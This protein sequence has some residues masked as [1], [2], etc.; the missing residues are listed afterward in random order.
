MREYIDVHCHLDGDEYDELGGLDYLVENALSRNVKYLV[1][2]GT[3]VETSYKAK[4]IAEKYENVYFTAGFQPEEVDKFK[5]GDLEKLDELLSHEKCVAV[6]EIGLDYHYTEDTKELQKEIFEKETCLAWKHGLPI[7]IHSRDACQDTVEFL[8]KH[9]ENVKKY[10]AVLHCYSYSKETMETLLPLGTYFSF[11]GTSTF[12]NA[13]RVR[14]CASTCPKDRILTETDCPYLT[15]EPNRGTF[16][17]VSGNVV[18]V[19][20]N[21][22]KMRSDDTLPEQIMLNARTFFKKLK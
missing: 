3:D 4:D 6:G 11:G 15:P 5:D 9:A 13:K 19:V 14:E 12:T 17:N 10:G 8:S 1:C 18:D 22:V 16:P 2:S 20:E 21:L 7:L